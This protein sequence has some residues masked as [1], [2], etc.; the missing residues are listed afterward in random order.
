MSNQPGDE[1]TIRQAQ[2]EDAPVCGRIC[3]DAFNTISQTHSFPC[4]FPG[5]DIATDL[6]SMLFSHSGFYCVVA[7]AGGRIAGSN[8]LDQRSTIAGV[9]P[10]TIDPDELNRGIG[11]KLMQAVLD[12]AREQGSPGVRFVQAAFHNRSLSLYASLGFD[13]R[14]PLSLPNPS[15]KRSG[16][17]CTC[18]ANDR[19]RC[20]QRP[21]QQVHGFDRGKAA[22]EWDYVL[23]DCPPT[24]GT[25]KDH[26]WQQS[27]DVVVPPP[28]RLQAGIIWDRGPGAVNGDSITRLIS[29]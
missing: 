17:R 10:I 29:L 27:L 13:I 5:P 11:R 4:D 22:D 12:R 16:M 21:R 2:P 20:L 14:E 3:Y 8:C 1:V 9:G 25:E 7:E 6:L 19:H 26:H 23:I 24:L 18:H 15:E 28:E